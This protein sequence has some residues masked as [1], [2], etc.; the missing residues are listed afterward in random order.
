MVGSNTYDED[1]RQSPNPNSQRS[2]NSKKTSFASVDKN[3]IVN[4]Q[5]YMSQNSNPDINLNLK[6]E[7]DPLYQHLSKDEEKE[8]N[9][10]ISQSGNKQANK[11]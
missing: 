2:S 3:R 6:N 7:S 1:G 10:F 11:D 4:N 5:N 8:M 9:R